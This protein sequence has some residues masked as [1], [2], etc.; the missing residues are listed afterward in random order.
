MDGEGDLSVGIGD[1]I[2]F[3]QVCVF[4]SLVGDFFSACFSVFF[5]P[6]LSSV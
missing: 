2:H 4:G 5:S 1:G 3:V 6:F